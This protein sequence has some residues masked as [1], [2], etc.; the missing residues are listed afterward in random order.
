MSGDIQSGRRRHAQACA[1]VLP[2]AS[3]TGS[4]QSP[5]V[6]LDVTC[7]VMYD[8]SVSSDLVYVLFNISVWHLFGLYVVIVFVCLVLIVIRFL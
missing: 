3:S 2:D 4:I 7:I 1:S 5:W 8:S 6:V